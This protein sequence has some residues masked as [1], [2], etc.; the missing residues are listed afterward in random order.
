MG[1]GKF[2]GGA[3]CAVGAVIAAPVVLPAMGAVATGAAATAAGAATAAAGTVGT[4]VAGAAGA[5][6]L[7]SVAAVA[8]TEAGAAALGAIATST[9][10]GVATGA[11][12]AKKM[13]E[14][15]GIQEAAKTRYSSA[16]T[17]FKKIETSTNKN[18]EELGKLKITIWE[19]FGR[20]LDLYE[21]ISNKPELSGKVSEEHIRLTEENLNNIKGVVLTVKDMLAGGAGAITTG[22]MIGLA[23]SGGLVSSITVASTGTAISSLSGAAAT[24]ATLAALGGGSLVSGG[25]GM[26]GGAMVMQGLTFAPMFAVGG[27]L[28]NMKAGKTLENARDIEYEVDEA[29]KKMDV[30]K[31]ELKKVSVL[32]VKVKKELENLKKSYEHLLSVME[33]VV[34]IKTDYNDFSYPERKMLESLT[35][36]VILLKTLSMQNILDSKQE[37]KVLEKEVEECIVQ[38]QKQEKEKLNM[39]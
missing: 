24:N 36:T 20:F 7:S 27:I 23:T 34:E 6:G 12:G 31:V 10:A 22:G 29:I 17:E 38:I 25:A 9:A 4:A 28:L 1:F 18:L 32:S 11:A 16:E 19:S 5:V 14:A 30:A 35:L 3:L 21:K 13:S 15:K 2:L 33:R 8:G 37:N 26:A 39:A